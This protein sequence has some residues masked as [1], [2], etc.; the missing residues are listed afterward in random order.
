[1][2]TYRG[3]GDP[4]E[5]SIFASEAALTQAVEAASDYADDSLSS[6]S[7]SA[8]SAGEA[9]ASAAAALV[10]ENNAETAETNAETAETNAETAQTA[11]ELAQT[12]A[13]TA[14]TAAELAETNAEAVYDDFDDR[15]LGAKAADPTLDNDGDALAT[16]ALYFKTAAAVGMKVYNGSTWDAAFDS[17]V[18]YKTGGTMT[19]TIAMNL[20]EE[21]NS[22][23]ALTI[24][25]TASNKASM[26]LTG[27]ATLTF[28]APADAS[29]LVLLISQDATGSRTITWPASVKWP[30]GI[31][32]TLT[33]TA[34]SV[35]IVSLFFDGTATFY[36]A[37]GLNYA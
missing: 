18:L 23:T 9:A 36:G 26:V 12:N 24:D 7:D 11:A 37:S 16:G 8:V 1:M 32:P 29:N 3:G 33:G 30:G 13:E 31:A 20:N 34:S 28:T 4:T 5:G 2:A 35:D 17:T 10:S 25:W 15:Y 22:S 6:A 27:N 21:G 14:Q 19:G